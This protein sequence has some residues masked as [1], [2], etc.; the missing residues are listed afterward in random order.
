MKGMIRLLKNNV[1]RKEFILDDC[2][3]KII[4]DLPDIKFIFTM[5]RN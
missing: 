5:Q 1:E 4:H 3:W 2:N